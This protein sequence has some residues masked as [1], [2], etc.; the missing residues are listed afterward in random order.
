M[1]YRSIAISSRHK[2]CDE[3][4]LQ[5]IKSI[6]KSIYVVFKWKMHSIEIKIKMYYII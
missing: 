2:M 1:V 6:S 4:I 5:T 3:H